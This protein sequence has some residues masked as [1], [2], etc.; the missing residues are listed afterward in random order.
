MPS[1]S[2]ARTREI[3]ICP[4]SNWLALAITLSPLNRRRYRYLDPSERLQDLRPDLSPADQQHRPHRIERRLA[5]V[6]R[7]HWL[8]DVQRQ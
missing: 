6:T 1:I 3:I 2:S 7:Q 5:V 8:D 4:R